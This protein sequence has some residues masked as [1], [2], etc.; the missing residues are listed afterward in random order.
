[1]K[2]IKILALFTFVLFAFSSCKKDRSGDVVVWWK[3]PAA[4]YVYYDLL[5][6]FVVVE[7]NGETAGILSASI[8]WNGAPS[9]SPS[10]AVNYTYELGKNKEALVPYKVTDEWGDIVYQGEIEFKDGICTTWELL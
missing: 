4:D 8:F 7:I 3:K 2:S 10:Q 5:S 9:C 1:M 6:D